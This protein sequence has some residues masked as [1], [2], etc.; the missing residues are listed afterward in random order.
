LASLRREEGLRRHHSVRLADFVIHATAVV[1]ALI[2][3]DDNGA[4]MPRL[5]LGELRLPAH[6]VLDDLAAAGADARGKDCQAQGSGPRLLSFAQGAPPRVQ[7]SVEGGAHFP[8]N[9]TKKRSFV[10]TRLWAA[11]RK[12]VKLAV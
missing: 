12:R 10:Q 1:T 3:R 4:L 6:Q 5:Q 2:L 7:A 9:V 11:I 8:S